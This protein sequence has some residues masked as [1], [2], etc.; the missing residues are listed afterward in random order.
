VVDPKS[1]GQKVGKRKNAKNTVKTQ[2]ESTHTN[3]IQSRLTPRGSMDHGN[4]I[5][6]KRR[7][8][9]IPG[10]KLGLEKGDW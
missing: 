5:T 3:P 10:E 1:K 4:K 8:G 9:R 6:R 2:E 7:E